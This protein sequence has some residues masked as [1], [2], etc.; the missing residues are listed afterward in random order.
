MQISFG[1]LALQKVENN[2]FV[3]FSWPCSFLLIRLTNVTPCSLNSLRMSVSVG[4]LDHSSEMTPH[5]EFRVGRVLT[6]IG[7]S[8]NLFDLRRR[9]LCFFVS[10]STKKAPF[11][12]RLIDFGLPGI[13]AWKPL[14]IGNGDNLVTASVSSPDS[15]KRNQGQFRALVLVS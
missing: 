7:L 12:S 4:Q 15:T 1:R 14:S 6:F 10:H 2:V 9:S 13:R 8:T 11:A 5:E 3:S